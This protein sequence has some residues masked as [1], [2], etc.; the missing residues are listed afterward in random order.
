MSIETELQRVFPVNFTPR[1]FFASVFPYVLALII[2]LCQ[3]IF[4]LKSGFIPANNDVL[5][6]IALADGVNLS[7]LSSLYNMFY[8][9]LYPLLVHGLPDGDRVAWLGLGSWVLNS[10]S[11]VLIAAIA[12]RLTGSMVASSVAVLILG[13]LPMCFR[14]FTTAGPDSL[15]ATLLLASLAFT[16]LPRSVTRS[17]GHRIRPSLAIAA[18]I[19]A[20]LAVTTRQHVLPLALGVLVLLTWN[21]RTRVA[22]SAAVAFVLPVAIQALISVSAGR[23]PLTSSAAFEI[24]RQVAPFDWY[25]SGQINP[26]SYSSILTTLLTHQAQF[27]NEW[28]THLGGFVLALTTLG[29]AAVVSRSRLETR[30]QRTMFCA[31]TIYVLFVSLGWSARSDLALAP[32][33]ALAG[34]SITAAALSLVPPPQRSFASIIAL[35]IAMIVALSTTLPQ[36]MLELYGRIGQEKSRAALEASLRINAPVDRA[37][38]VVT[39]DYELFFRSIPGN[40]PYTPGGWLAVGAN[41]HERRAQLDL[42]SVES[43]VCSADRLGLSSS[44][45][46]GGRVPHVPVAIEQMLQDGMRPFTDLQTTVRSLNAARAGT[47]CAAGA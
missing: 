45:W 39:D 21:N 37:I 24:F 16:V 38:Q 41:G 42:R 43:F 3:F 35:T 18:G 27:F 29:V 33:L 17:E 40:V 30:V 28:T 34:A 6:V 12:K 11:L 46:L 15:A 20:G 13:F 36:G 4:G 32:F 26:A 1:T 25:T 9:F 7:Q 10:V 14:Y 47:R 2:A 5:G 31:G 8:P 23:P 44:V 22:I 19:C